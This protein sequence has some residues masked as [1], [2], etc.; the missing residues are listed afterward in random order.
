M[1]TRTPL[2]A[3][4]LAALVV[5]AGCA[6]APTSS[7]VAQSIESTHPECRVEQNSKLVLGRTKL[8]AVR[9]LLNLAGEDVDGEARAILHHLRRIEVSSYNLGSGCKTP[10]TVMDPV[11]RFVADGWTPMVTDVGNHDLTWVMVREDAAGEV[12]GML[13]VSVDPNELEVIRL[14]G[15]INELLMEAVSRDPAGALELFSGES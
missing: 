1:K 9:G 15:Q 11:N 13:V 3:T 14:D 5:A 12:A 7:R 8:F 4:P 2:F 6:S 10:D